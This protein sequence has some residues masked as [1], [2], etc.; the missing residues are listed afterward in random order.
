MVNKSNVSIDNNLSKHSLGL[1]N[2]SALHTG[3]NII[4]RGYLAGYG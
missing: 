1:I 2:I 4:G 3:W